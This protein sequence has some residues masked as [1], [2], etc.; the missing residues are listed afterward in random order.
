MKTGVYP[1]LKKLTPLLLV[2][3]LNRAISFY[4]GSLGFEISFCYEDF[5]AGMVKDGCTI[6]L[7]LGNPY[8]EER[9]D[10]RK[11]ED[12][13]LVLSIDNIQQFYDTIDKTSVS[14]VQE[15]REMPYGMEFYIADPDGYI[16]S[17]LSV[18]DG[19]L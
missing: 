16:I 12:I 18:N 7:K 4:N 17:F 19:S 6:H 3:D 2:A 14:I 10:R 9:E 13:D 1:T 8:P 5:Y 15:L 11:N